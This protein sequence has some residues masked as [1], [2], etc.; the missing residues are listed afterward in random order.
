MSNNTGKLNTCTWLWLSESEQTTPVDSIKD[1]V[2]SSVKVPE[3]DK[4]LKEAEGHIGW[5]VVEITIK[6]KTIVQKPFMIKIIKLRL[7][8]LDNWLR[9][10]WV[11]IFSHVTRFYMIHKSSYRKFNLHLRSLYDPLNNRNSK[12]YAFKIF[13]FYPHALFSHLQIAFPLA[14]LN[15]SI[16]LSRFSKLQVLRPRDFGFFLE[17]QEGSFFLG[18]CITL[19]FL[20]RL[21]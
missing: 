10:N 20:T 11:S 1:V 8:N 7:R 21:T 9:M 14:W 18:S 16:H 4:H 19:L 5:N 17:D 13:I 6:M 2:R 12:F 3:F 15:F